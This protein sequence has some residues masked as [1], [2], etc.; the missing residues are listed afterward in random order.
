MIPKRAVSAVV[1]TLFALTLLLS[2]KTPESPALAGP[3]AA[4]AAIVGTATPAPTTDATNPAVTAA[5]VTGG[6]DPTTTAATYVD[7]TVTGPVVANRF[8]PVQVQVTISGGV[9]T[10]V[11]ALQLPSDDRRSASISQAAEPTLRSEALAAQDASIDLV[12]G[13]TFTSASYR[14]SLQAALDQAAA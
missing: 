13:A 6:T 11:T 1:T 14:D 2:F 8:G 3:S 4:D 10:D 7:G 9:V 12:S 5:P